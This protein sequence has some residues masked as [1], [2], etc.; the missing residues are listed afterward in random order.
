[1]D[2][3]TKIANQKKR[4]KELSEKLQVTKKTHEEKLHLHKLETNHYKTLA[5]GQYDRLGF[6]VRILEAIRLII[7]IGR[8]K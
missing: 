2:S 8:W 1:M 5:D 6:F 7:G 4:I 3:I